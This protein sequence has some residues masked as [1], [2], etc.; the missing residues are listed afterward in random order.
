VTEAEGSISGG[1][2]FGRYTLVRPIGRGGMAEIWKARIHGAQNFQRLVVVK[3]ILPH[4]CL[5]PELVTMFTAEAMLSAQLNHGNIVQVFEFAENE[6]ELYLAMEYVH[7]VNLAELLKRLDQVPIPAAMAAY[8]VREVALALAY[9]HA[10]KD[11][12]GRSLSIIHRDVSPSNVMVGYDGSVKLVDFGV[13]MARSQGAGSTAMGS[14]KGKV[15]YMSPEALEGELELDGRTDIFAAGVLLHELLTAQRLFRA[16]D[17]RHTMALVRACK[18]RP[19]SRLRSDVPPELDRIVARALARDRRS[20]Y[21]TADAFAAELTEV[22]ARCR[23]D[24]MHTAAFLAEHGIQP[25]GESLP[26]ATVAD[27]TVRA[28]PPPETKRITVVERRPRSSGS[29][30][31]VENGRRLRWALTGAAAA[32][33]LSGA[34]A[35]GLR[36]SRSEPA[37]F[38]PVHLQIRQTAAP[39]HHRATG[40]RI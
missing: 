32:L 15:A 29:L 26:D 35:L 1:T 7:G 25:G 17:D 33:A 2:R 30:P 31:P 36:L 11:E 5:D 38:A 18:V 21:S 13:A 19:P 24:R 20:R 6:G 4:L 28:W 12:D 9:A 23:W 16:H 3:R 22:A 14:L 37:G 8:L 34:L 40:N 10:L 27:A 39:S